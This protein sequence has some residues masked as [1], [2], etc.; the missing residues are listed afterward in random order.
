MALTTSALLL[1][2]GSAAVYGAGVIHLRIN[3]NTPVQISANAVDGHMMV[4]LTEIASA[5]GKK[6]KYDAKTHTAFLDDQESV[7]AKKAGVLE[8]TGTKQDGMYVNLKLKHN[9]I[10]R[11]PGWM[12]MA[13]PSYAPQIVQADLNKDG[14]QETVIVLNEGYGTGVYLTKAHVMDSHL[15]ETPLEDPLIAVGRQVHMSFTKDGARLD[16]NGKT[17]TVPFSRIVS[18]PSYRF[19]APGVGAI[20]RYSIQGDQLKATLPVQVSLGEFIGDLELEYGYDNGI[21]QVKRMTFVEDAL[22]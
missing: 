16:L 3:G 19:E 22:N 5:L 17:V 15:I 12:N 14:E 2:G 1:L 10:V 21:Y 6:V 8:I 9:D 7:I 18:E 4:P 11:S 20:I 13:N